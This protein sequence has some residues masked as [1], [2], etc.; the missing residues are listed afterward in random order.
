MTRG[1]KISV[2]HERRVIGKIIRD[3]R[4]SLGITQEDLAQQAG[5][6]RLA[7]I[8]IEQGRPSEL[9]SILTLFKLLNCELSISNI[10]N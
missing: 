3:K 5:L 1:I 4:K 2:A 7:V 8:N 9:N 6:K 10:N